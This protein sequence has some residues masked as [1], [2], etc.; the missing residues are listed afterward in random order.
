MFVRA[1]LVAVIL[2]TTTYAALAQKPEH[3]TPDA[4]WFKRQHSVTGAW[5]C[6]IS[7]GHRLHEE[8]VRIASGMHSGW[9]IR[10]EGKWFDVPS[11]AERGNAVDDPNPTGGPVAWYM[12]WR[13]S[14][15]SI[16][17]KIYCFAPGTLS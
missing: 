1:I 4:E 16:D 10:V 3:P 6:D 7:D 11:D 9:Q 8:D 12:I 5:C 13:Q 14:D 15:G 2:A 17:L